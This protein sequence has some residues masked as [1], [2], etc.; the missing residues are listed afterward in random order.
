MIALQ[1][2]L[3][4]WREA[5]TV[6]VYG[7]SNLHDIGLCIVMPNSILERIVDCAHHRKINNAQDLKCE[8][9]WS[10]AE[11]YGT[12][13]IALLQRH[14][15]PLSTPFI[16][17]PLRPLTCSI[18]NA[19]PSQLGPPSATIP[20]GASAPSNSPSV[21][22]VSK[23]QIKCGACGGVGHNARNQLCPK[24]P[25]HMNNQNKENTTPSV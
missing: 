3:D 1:E 19:S 17:T 14:A 25:S 4:D 9:G 6:A 12:K 22:V 13:I 16:T 24:H 11:Q 15:P 8:T 21:A 18:V 10:D 20:T 23:R 7:W 5:K 2:A